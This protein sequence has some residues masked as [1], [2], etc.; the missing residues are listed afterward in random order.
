MEA[1]Y[2]SGSEK[3]ESEKLVSKLCR[4][5]F[6]SLWSYSN[7]QGKN[8]SKE[9]C[10]NLV[11]CDPDVIIFSVK[12][13][14]LSNSGDMEVDWKRWLREAVKKSYDQAY[15]A[16]RWINRT[17]RVV[18]SDGEA[19]LYYPDP[20]RRKIHRIVVAF[21][22]RRQVPFSSGD[23]GKGFVHVIDEAALLVLLTELDTISDF[24]QYLNDKEAFF[25]SGIQAYV[26]GGE[27]D[28]LSWCLINNRKF[29]DNLDRIII[30]SGLWANFEK[31][32]DYQAK[33][34]EDQQSYVWDNVIEEFSGHIR[35][36]TLEYSAPLDITEETI[37][38]MAREN[39]FSRRNL[40]KSFLEFIE[41]TKIAPHR[42]RYS[43]SDYS[44]VAYV[45]LSRPHGDDRQDRM[46]ELAMR[47]G[48]VKNRHPDVKKVFG[49][50]TE[51]YEPGSGRSFDA[52]CIDKEEWTAEDV[53]L[54]ELIQKEYQYFVAPTET[55]RQ[56]DEFP[57]P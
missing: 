30:E 51:A 36:G 50:A 25:S 40:G 56:E 53:A 48:V 5:S 13:K 1:S 3:N 52:C 57:T 11:V 14:K 38:T 12:D 39:R 17:S 6:L 15:G 49:I 4:R 28:V 9:L 29:P 24:V 20:G 26:A 10:D 18:M 31:R 23:F 27:E 33:K 55:R 2:V 7:P 19:G 35:K 45:F 37:R 22:G 8:P 32:P 47:C 21:G 41:L 43:I 44:G 46:N 42:S 16:E 54:A 34:I